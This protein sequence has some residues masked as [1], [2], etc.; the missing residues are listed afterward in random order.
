[1]WSWA[2]SALALAA[3]LGSGCDLFHSTEWQTACAKDATA[4]GCAAASVQSGGGG[5]LGSG[6]GGTG[7]ADATG[8]GAL[9]AGG[10]AVDGGSGGEPCVPATSDECS[11][12]ADDDCNG[13]LNDACPAVAYRMLQTPDTGT[14]AYFDE[15][16]NLVT[17]GNAADN[18][19]CG[20]LA[21]GQLIDGVKGADLIGADLGQGPAFEWVAWKYEPVDIDFDFGVVRTLAAVEVGLDNQDAGGVSQPLSV[22]VSFSA[23]GASFDQPVAFSLARG[24]LPPIPAGKRGDV[25]LSF[26]AIEARYVRLSFEPGNNW[27]FVDEVAFP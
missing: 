5:E 12:A 19:A 4:D 22:T 11:T 14:Y 3:W 1:M 18:T 21:P 8:T 20:E 16:H 27:V 23:D 25:L 7:A 6:A 15:T 2:R 17:S 24:T 26:S 13:V 9:G 10:G